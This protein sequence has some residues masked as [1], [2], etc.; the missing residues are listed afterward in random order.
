MNIQ[1]VQNNNISMQGSNSNWSRF[2]RKI[3]QKIFDKIPDITIKDSDKK[4]RKWNDINDKI[5]RPGNNRLI[6]GISAI[7][8]QPFFDFF[9][10]KVDDETRAVSTI[11]TISK[12]I[13]GTGVGI[14]VRNSVYNTIEKMTQLEGKKKY[15]KSLLPKSMLSEIAKN[16]TFLKNHR[17]ALSMAV[18]IGVMTFTN[19]LIDAPLTLLLTNK[20]NSLRQDKINVANNGIDKGVNING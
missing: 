20:L 17:S 4:I 16:E 19:F 6:M 9:N 13:V 15:S 5:S 2:K 3:E 12:I 14:V 7:M 18:A 1:P 11:R 8:S 10:K